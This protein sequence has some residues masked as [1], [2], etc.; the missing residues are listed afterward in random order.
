[1]ADHQTPKSKRHVV[2]R[3]LRTESSNN[4]V[5]M[6]EFMQSHPTSVLQPNH[7]HTWPWVCALQEEHRKHR[8]C[9][10]R[11]YTLAT[12]DSERETLF[13]LMYLNCFFS[14]RTLS[15]YHWFIDPEPYERM[16]GWEEGKCYARIY[17]MPA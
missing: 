6:Q 2:T 10:L 3:I 8:T 15:G 1:M 11:D 17:N 12:A 5:P 16:R 13:S 14:M 4:A 9:I 7:Y